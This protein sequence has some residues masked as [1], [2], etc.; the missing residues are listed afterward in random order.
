MSDTNLY[1]DIW[2]PL[3]K[4][5]RDYY[6]NSLGSRIETLN[7][8]IT[9]TTYYKLIRVNGDLKSVWVSE[10]EVIDISI[11]PSL[12]Y[13]PEWAL[14]EGL[15]NSNTPTLYTRRN[16]VLIPVQS[17]YSREEAKVTFAK[18]QPSSGSSE[19]T[20]FLSGVIRPAAAGFAVLKALG[21][22]VSD[23]FYTTSH[24]FWNA[25]KMRLLD[26]VLWNRI[27]TNDK[28][29][30]IVQIDENGNVTFTLDELAFAYIAKYLA[31]SGMFSHS[32][33]IPDEFNVSFTNRHIISYSFTDILPDYFHG[34]GDYYFKFL[35]IIKSITREHYL[36]V[37]SSKTKMA[38][39]PSTKG[40]SKGL[41]TIVA[42]SSSDDFEGLA[43]N[44]KTFTYNDKT[45]YYTISGWEL[46]NA[47]IDSYI[48]F[49]TYCDVVA[50]SDDKYVA[51]SMIYSASNIE[52]ISDQEGAIIPNINADDTVEQI[53]QT[54]QNTYPNVWDK[55]ITRNLVTSPDE[56]LTLENEQHEMIPIPIS[57]KDN[58]EN[59]TPTSD[60]D[61]DTQFDDEFDMSEATDEQLVDI[62]DTLT[63][64][65]LE[66]DDPEPPP[67]GEGITPVVVPPAG[68][69]ESLWAVYNPTLGET[70]SFNAW[71]WSD[72]FVDQLLKLFSNP[73]E[74]IIGFHKIFVPPVVA[75]RR[76]IKVGYLDSGVN[77]NY[78][79]N[80]YSTVDCGS[81]RL[82][83]Q[84]LNV[85]DYA[86]YTSIHLYLPFIGIVELDVA[87]VMRSTI[88]VVYHGDVLTGACLA[89][90]KVKR[91][92]GGGTIYSFNG[93]CAVHYPL[94]SGS[95][96]GVVSSLLGLAG[97]VASLATGNIVGGLYGAS[98][99]FNPKS[100]VSLSGN[101]S[102]N[103]GAMGIKKPYL[104]IS[105]PQSAMASK[106]SRFVGYPANFYT[107]LSMC[108]GYTKV[109]VAHVDNISTATEEEKTM[110]EN[111][112]KNGVLIS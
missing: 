77:S 11:N 22:T 38:I 61:L 19:N 94:S 68:T 83:E 105:R 20:T 98:N 91:D 62:I 87:D 73:M 25:A 35:Y 1:T 71:L 37:F 103:A 14:I 23:T 30:T 92:G 64:S 53:L 8:E 102:G 51:W 13:V 63:Q 36:T 90:V 7:E 41:R 27:T 69:T 93:D 81:V 10:G 40:L 34:Y 89:E 101:L 74:A 76:N 52:G 110:I 66:E 86:P 59:E 100:S 43:R 65:D 67:T 54:L 17:F 42:G 82:D 99:F 24:D 45:V 109:N 21:K 58:L 57:K 39:G 3:S 107:K 78:I 95:Y 50:E 72:N 106:F 26:P 12:S 46:G 79:G 111:A 56:G 108:K 5:S 32:A 48:G 84:F 75:G 31:V 104:I 9:D 112:L 16:N 60:L 80:Q 33:I 15:N 29:N 2:Q 18:L 6:G 28:F 96:M 85:F 97:G 55:K 47:T 4:A 70:Q 44:L 49:N 88:N